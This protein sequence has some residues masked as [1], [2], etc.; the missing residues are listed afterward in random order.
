MRSRRTAYEA[1]V[2]AEVDA[3]GVPHVVGR[4]QQLA[5]RRHRRDARAGRRQPAP[6]RAGAG[7]RPTPR[8][9][10][11]TRVPAV[12][13]TLVA[14]TNWP[15]AAHELCNRPVRAAAAVGTARCTCRRRSCRP[16]RQCLRRRRNPVELAERRAHLVDDVR[17]VRAEPAAALGGVV[18]PRRA[19]R[20]RGRPASASAART[21]RSAD[22]RS[23]RI[24]TARA[25]SAWPGAKRNSVPSR[26]TTPAASAAA[27]HLARL[28]QVA[29]ERLL[30]QHVLA[31]RD[32][33]EHDLGVRVRWRGDRDDVDVVARERLGDGRS[34]R[35]GSPKRSARVAV[36]SGSRPTS[37]RTS[38]PAASQGAH[39]GEARRSRCRRRRRRGCRSW[40]CPLVCRGRAHDSARLRRM[41]DH[42][43]DILLVSHTHWDREWYRTFEAFRGPARRHR[44][45]GA[46]AARRGP[47]AG[48][49]CSTAR[50]SWSRTTSRCGPTAAPSSR[51]AV[52][53]GRL[54]LGP[55]VRAARLAAAGGR[56]ARAQPAGGPAGGGVARA[57]CSTVAY[58]PDSFGHPAQF[59]QLFAGFGL[60]PV[61]LLARQR[62]RARPPRAR[63]T[64]GSRPTAAACSRTTSGAGYFAAAVLPRD[65]DDGGRRPARRAR[66]ASARSSGRPRC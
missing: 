65:P 1:R 16:R 29:G 44:R 7:R 47:R 26:W 20:P 46:R 19:S 5:R 4:V 14:T 17:A 18:P 34:S 49:S 31:G 38:K 6:G 30:A 39:V 2:R 64:A 52:R 33:V 63:S 60:G 9:P 32:R 42:P 28:G 37:A 62:R 25:S 36:L 45:P 13:V 55:V 54:A 61:R 24:A 8:R 58:V 15:P 43:V 57:R 23:R 48:T 66:T 22:R 56:V 27:Q 3:G 21:A 11:S 59:P 40:S 41:A 50:R 53:D 35:A 10:A 12:P 51:Q